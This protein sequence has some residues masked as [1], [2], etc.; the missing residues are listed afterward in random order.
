MS[1]GGK[2]SLRRVE[3]GVSPQGLWRMAGE[4]WDFRGLSPRVQRVGVFTLEANF[5]RRNLSFSFLILPINR[6]QSKIK[7]FQHNINITKYK[8]G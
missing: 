6:I 2:R 4:F 1:L 3:R 7:H 5:A 8:P